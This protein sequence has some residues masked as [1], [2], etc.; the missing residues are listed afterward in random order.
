ME[1][2]LVDD[3]PAIVESLEKGIDWEKAGVSKVHTATSAKVAKLLLTNFPIDIMICDIEMPEESGLELVKWTR[4]HV[5]GVEVVFLTSHAEFDYIKEAMHLGCFD[6]IL[7]PVKFQEVVAVIEKLQEKIQRE[8][9]YQKMVK[10]TEKSVDQQNYILE[11]LLRE[12]SEGNHGETE[13]ITKDYMGLYQYI[14][15]DSVVYQALI[16]I[17]HWKKLIHR[18]HPHE[19][20]N[21]L[22]NICIRLLDREKIHVAVTPCGTDQYWLLVFAERGSVTAV[23]WQQQ[24]KDLYDFICSNMEFSIAVYYANNCTSENLLDTYHS[25]LQLRE[26][27]VGMESGKFSF[28]ERETGS[29]SRHPAISDALR[30]IEGHMNQNLSRTEVA[31]AINVSEEYFSRLFK[32]ET[33]STFKEYVLDMK[34]KQAKHLLDTTDL[35]VGII[36]SKVGYSNFSYFSQLFR[37]YEGMTPQEYRK[38]NRS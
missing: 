29:Y 24:M 15:E 12:D 19:M 30:Y 35:S 18:K 22:K 1:V 7:Q 27:N 17:V 21:I 14:F 36:A 37:T 26:K 20:V 33:G 8:R 28:S 16:D 9:H 6:Y 25:M 23:M 34:M 32:Q 31:D 4:E 3:F 13:R 11:R 5:E 10:L 2:L 38:G